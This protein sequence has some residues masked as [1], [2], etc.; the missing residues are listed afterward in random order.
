MTKKKTSAANAKVYPNGRKRASKACFECQKRHTRCGFERP[1][2]RCVRLGL[3]CVDMTSI[4]KRGRSTTG[5]DSDT[6]SSP[7]T[8]GSPT[9]ANNN[10]RRSSS[11]KPATTDA[12]SPQ[13]RSSSK[14]SPKS[15]EQAESPGIDIARIEQ[16]DGGILDSLVTKFSSGSNPGGSS[17]VNNVASPFGSP[18]NIETPQGINPERIGAVLS[19]PDFPNVQCVSDSVVRRLN[20]PQSEVT[21]MWNLFDPEF[22]NAEVLALNQSIQKRQAIIQHVQGGIDILRNGHLRLEKQGKTF[23]RSRSSTNTNG[24]EELNYRFFFTYNTENPSKLENVYMFLLW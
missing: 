8:K 11:S 1:C 9:P 22:V 12:S 15:D 14:K 21:S 7:T 18:S 23:V 4:K 13:Q 3:N 19:G 16:G 20:I 6:T 24:Y 5:K 10:R 17:I 2:E